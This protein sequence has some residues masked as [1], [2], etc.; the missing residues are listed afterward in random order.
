MASANQQAMIVDMFSS[1][2]IMPNQMDVQNTPLYDTATVTAGNTLSTPASALFTTVGPA[3][4]KTYAQTN[5]QVARQLPSPEAFAILGF[6]LRY[7]ENISVLDLFNLLNGFAFEFWMN[8]KNYQRG[9]IPFYA[10]G[11]GVYG[12][13]T[14]AATNIFN[15]GM[16]DRSGMHKTAVTL[17][18]ENTMTFYAQLAGNSVV[19]NGA[20]NGVTIQCVLDGLYARGVA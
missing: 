5:M 1:S 2:T 6:R 12:F 13:S 14:V 3:S 15:N 18:I 4:G 11:M 8:N 7:S 19:V 17:V 10:A 20:G 16:P 9:P